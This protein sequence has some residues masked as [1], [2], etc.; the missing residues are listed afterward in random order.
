MRT[1]DMPEA[2]ITNYLHMRANSR[3]FAGPYPIMQPSGD[4]YTLFFNSM[5]NAAVTGASLNC[6]VNTP[7]AVCGDD[8][9]VAGSWSYQKYFKPTQWS[10]KPKREQGP[11]G[12]FCGLLFGQR[13]LT[14]S[15]AGLT[16]RCRIGLQ[17]GEASLDYWR[18]AHEMLALT[19]AEDFEYSEIHQIFDAARSLLHSKIPASY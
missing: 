3:T 10:I 12:T 5:C 4:R 19:S 13:K 9:I 11:T 14:V 16:Y 1:F 2:Y 7:A 8:S 15:L 17:R 18:S 6:P